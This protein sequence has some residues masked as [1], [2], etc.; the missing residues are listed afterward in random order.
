[1]RIINPATDEVLREVAAEGASEVAAKLGDAR[2]AQPAWARAP[3]AER[4][5][6]VGRFRALVY[7]SI[8]GPPTGT[9]A[10]PRA[11]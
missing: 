3:F 8:V 9:A 1:M 10:G 5:A 6:A 11:R 4:R 7:Q 2:E